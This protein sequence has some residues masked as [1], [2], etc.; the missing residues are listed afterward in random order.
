MRVYNMKPIMVLFLSLLASCSLFDEEEANALSDPQATFSQAEKTNPQQYTEQVKLLVKELASID[1]YDL[2]EKNTII[3]T[4]VWN[5][6]FTS[7]SDNM[8]LKS[9]GLHLA[10]Q[11]KYEL[12]HQ[13]A[14]VIEGYSGKSLAISNEGTYFLSRDLEALYKHIDADYVVTGVMSKQKQGIMVNAYV[15]DFASKLIVGSAQQLFPHT[16]FTNENHV[17][18]KDGKIFVSR[19]GY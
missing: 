15:I 16:V 11:T 18:L 12:V 8:G 4:F 1:K 7:E 6:S 19:E 9:L 5:E 13:N 10:E 17:T 2:E 14:N 3:S